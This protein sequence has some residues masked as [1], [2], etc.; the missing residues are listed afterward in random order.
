MKDNIFKVKIK[1]LTPIWTGDAW[2]ESNELKLTGIIGS[3]RWWFE[4]LVRGMGYKACDVQSNPC[5]VE[6][7]EPDDILNIHKK[8][9]PACFLFGTTGWRSRI[10][11]KIEKDNLS[12]PYEG[13]IVFK[14]GNG[15]GWHYESGLMGEATLKAKIDEFIFKDGTKLTE[16][17]SAVL[18]ILL[19]L[20]QEYG[21][22]GAKTSTGYGVVKFKVDDNDISVSG[23]DW[24]NFNTYLRLFDDKF[25]GNINYLPNL[26][27]MFFVK[28][29]VNDSI[30]NLINNM[31]SLMT[32][33][34]GII[35][36][37]IEKWKDKNWVISSPVVRKEIRKSIKNKFNNNNN[38]RHFLMGKVKGNN[39]TFSAIQ[40]SH[41]YNN[42]GL[43][44]RIWGWLPDIY[45][46]KGKVSD[47]L[48]L[49]KGI[50]NNPTW[51]KL[52]GNIQNN[53]CWDGS[54][55]ELINGSDGEDTRNN[56]KRLFI[57]V[58]ENVTT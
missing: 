40:V 50:F 18:K 24:D 30:A 13:K 8:I 35:E 44:F 45:P 29:R 49:L 12:K 36:G 31:R 47:I 48:N 46:I 43:E 3:L 11:I 20:I 5:S 23:N 54:T 17:V 28:F 53:I 57:E 51:N 56:I 19:Y 10:S 52:N 14:I 7:G 34:N 6:I 21:M 1:T 27:D 16:I 38:L 2:R 55:L 25:K 22:L 15:R 41:V 26:K 33:Q 42:N 9:C 32:A 39:S 4:A 58:D 37:A